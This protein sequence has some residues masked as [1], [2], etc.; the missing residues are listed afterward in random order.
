M[1]ALRSVECL[2]CLLALKA[3]TRPIEVLAS[4]PLLRELPDGVAD[5]AR[6]RT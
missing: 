4:Y 3:H 6:E 5:D 1:R 2:P